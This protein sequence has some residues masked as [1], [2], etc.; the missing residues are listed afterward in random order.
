M[1]NAPRSADPAAAEHDV[2]VVE[3]S[4]L[5]WSDGTLWRVERNARDGGVEWLDIGGRGFVLVANL[6]EGAKRAGRL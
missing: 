3:Y 4:G 2:T 1:R 5:A 6:G